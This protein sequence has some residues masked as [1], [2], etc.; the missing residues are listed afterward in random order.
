VSESGVVE[1]VTSTYDLRRQGAVGDSAHYEYV[2]E[3]LT[4]GPGGQV[5]RREVVSGLY[6]EEILGIRPD[7]ARVFHWTRRG[8]TYEL[9]VPAEE[10]GRVLLEELEGFELDLCFEDDFS[11]V[12]VEHSV[13]PGDLTG[14]MMYEHIIHSS[15]FGVVTSARHGSVDQLHS[16]GD[17]TRMGFS[18]RKVTLEFGGF[19]SIQMERGESAVTFKGLGRAGAEPG[20]LVGFDLPQQL[21]AIA[22]GFG[23]GDVVG[24]VLLSL[25]DRSILSGSL[26]QTNYLLLG[27]EDG[28]AINQI[29]RGTLNRV[30]TDSMTAS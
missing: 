12:P 16:V 30:H 5:A 19:M 29:V 22:G 7:G 25:E 1:A 27:G 23:R 6:R 8:T 4:L 20:A 17:R 14:M 13:F 15:V 3:Y 9:T 24:E 21:V 18:G 26:Q 10:G 28:I 2:D 11:L